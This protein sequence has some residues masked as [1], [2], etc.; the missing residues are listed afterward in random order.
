VVLRLFIQLQLQL[1]VATRSAWRNGFEVEFKRPPAPGRGAL[2]NARRNAVEVEVKVEIERLPRPARVP[3]SA[4]DAQT[5]D[6]L[7]FAQELSTKCETK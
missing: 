4:S 5:G 7:S 3:Q 1:R 6:W 2:I